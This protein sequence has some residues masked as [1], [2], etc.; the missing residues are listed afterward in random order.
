MMNLFS[1]L[2]TNEGEA[3]EECG[4]ILQKDSAAVLYMSKRVKVLEDWQV[5]SDLSPLS[6]TRQ[7][8]ISCWP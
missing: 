7:K 3:G 4:L 1:E 8:I 6:K 5:F 2:E